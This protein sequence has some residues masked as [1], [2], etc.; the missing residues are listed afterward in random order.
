MYVRMYVCL[1]VSMNVCIYEYECVIV[2]F[3]MQVC[4]YTYTC[5]KYVCVFADVYI[6]VY[7]YEFVYV[8]VCVGTL[9]PVSNLDNDQ[10]SVLVNSMT[11]NEE[12]ISSI[13]FL[14]TNNNE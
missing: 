10:L 5:I 8:C 6:Y 12:E 7:T 2:Y 4:N 11:C 13:I 3:K 9:S 1:H 14:N